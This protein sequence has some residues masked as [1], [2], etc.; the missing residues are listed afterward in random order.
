MLSQGFANISVAQE[1]NWASAPKNPIV[2][3][4]TRN[5]FHLFGPVEVLESQDLF[6]TQQQTFSTEGVLLKWEGLT[7]ESYVYKNGKPIMRIR[8]RDTVFFISNNAGQIITERFKQKNITSYNYSKSGQLAEVINIDAGS[9]IKYTYDDKNRLKQE[10]SYDM[11]GKLTYIEENNYSTTKENML[12]VLSKSKM[13]WK[14]KSIDSTDWLYKITL[15]NVQGQLTETTNAGDTSR[16]YTYR[17]TYDYLGNIMAEISGEKP[18]YQAGIKYFADQLPSK[19]S[20]GC[21]GGN[22]INGYGNYK[23]QDKEY[24]GFFKNGKP[25]GFGSMTYKDGSTHGGNW[26]FGT[27]EGYGMFTQPDGKYVIGIYKND[28]LDGY[29]E[30]FTGASPKYS[31]YSKNKV[32]KEFKTEK[33]DST[34]RCKYG[35]CKDGY[36]VYIYE[37]G[38]YFRGFFKNSIAKMGTYTFKNGDVYQGNFNNEGQFEGIGTYQFKNGDRYIGKWNKGKYNYGGSFYNKAKNTYSTGWYVNG[39]FSYVL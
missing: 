24:T 13:S 17:K 10:T 5:H 27:K 2:I 19:E 39:N 20:L 3:K 28:L 8:H 31:M 22:C 29:V 38:D 33:N 35:D 1:I 15:Y 21:K 11:N 37:S 16:L 25:F 23:Y 4:Y 7:P 12:K 6:G 32:D 18:V 34:N 36:G 9:K 26:E 30:D 14:N